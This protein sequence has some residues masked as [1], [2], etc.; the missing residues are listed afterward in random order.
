MRLPKKEQRLGTFQLLEAI[1][2]TFRGCS[3]PKSIAEALFALSR[4]TRNE[5]QA[6]TF[7]G[8]ADAG[9]LATIAEWLLDLRVTMVKTDG[10]VIFTN[11]SDLDNVQVHIIFRDPAEEPSQTL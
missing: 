6:V 3:S 9:W 10:E 2:K 1:P 5:L 7:I 11:Y 4:I 8:G